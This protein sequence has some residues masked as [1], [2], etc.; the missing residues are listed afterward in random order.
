MLLVNAKQITYKTRI[1]L[2]LYLLDEVDDLPMVARELKDLVSVLNSG[3]SL[4]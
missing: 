3:V 2:S 1:F 4:G